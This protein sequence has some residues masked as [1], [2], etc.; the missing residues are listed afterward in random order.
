MDRR[1]FI[2]LSAKSA[3]V[4]ALS[5][6]GAALLV[7]A[8]SGVATAEEPELTAASTTSIVVAAAAQPSSFAFDFS[9]LGY[10]AAEYNANCQA[11]LVKNPYNIK[12]PQGDLE[13]NYYV[14]KPYLAES[15]EVSADGLTYTFHLAKGVKSARGNPLTAD[16]V[17]YSYER[18]WKAA[19]SITP[20]VTSPAITDPSKQLKKIDDHTVS[21]T[22]AEKGYG[23]TLM[24]LLANVTAEIYDSTVLKQHASAS[25][26]YAVKWSATNGNFGFGPYMLESYTPGSQLVLVANPN[27]NLGV[28]PIGKITFNLVSDPGNR[29]TEVKLGSVDV[30][31]QL[32]PSD[33]AGMASNKAVQTFTVDS[34]ANT[35]MTINTSKAPF[36]NVK[37]REAL[38]WAI[39]YSQIIKNVYLGR[40]TPMAGLL[41]PQA[42][43]YDGTGLPQYVYNPT[44]AKQLLKEAG[45]TG[46]ASFTLTVS[47]A[48]PDVQETAI[49]I[50]SFA[51]AAGFDV[52]IQQL[53]A[54]AFGT[55]GSEGNFQ[56]VMQ[57][58]YAISQSPPYELLL[59]FTPKSPLNESKWDDPAF[60]DAVNAGNAL[61]NPL[62]KAGGQAWNKAEKIML[63]QCPEIW[64][65]YV[66]PLNVVSSKLT[67]WAHR[68]DN[69]IDFF[70]LKPA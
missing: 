30:A 29:A 21:F 13:Q 62:S 42:P 6:T 26:P 67:G 47:N 31:E 57:R 63:E 49:Q 37:V 23:F 61:G 39:P 69:V 51:K 25:D 2:G 17:I 24:S 34:N 8:G 55:A 27:H 45:V 12:S 54:A 3:G 48:V 4:L 18:K 35:Y 5:G 33:V 32:A 14:F 50:Q 64:I 70:N 36:N 59:F 16:D 46:N 52:T 9:A 20:F 65:C 41:D 56:V 7:D 66:Q 22:V 53:P 44:K 28:A 40:A 11:T 19:T 15:Y 38:A 60:V 68:S 10:E 43:G 58:D 1:E